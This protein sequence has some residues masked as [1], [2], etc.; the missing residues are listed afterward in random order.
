MLK[1][2]DEAETMAEGTM[3]SV[4]LEKKTFLLARLD[5]EFYSVQGKCTHL[6]CRLADGQLEGQVVTCPCH[7]SSFD[8]TSGI[9]VKWIGGWPQLVRSVTKKMGFA[10]NL[11]TF[12]VLTKKDGIYLDLGGH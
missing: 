9:I 7:G 2:I 3:R 1:K 5:G 11:K 12:P 8:L 4:V 10:R 6:G